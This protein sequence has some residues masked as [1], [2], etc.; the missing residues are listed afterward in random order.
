MSAF[1]TY[2][3]RKAGIAAR[4][5]PPSLIIITESP[6][7]ISAGAPVRNS[8]VA[9]KTALRNLI[10]DCGSG[11]TIRG[12]TVCH[13]SGRCFDMLRGLRTAF[14][15]EFTWVPD[16]RKASTPA[17]R[18]RPLPCHLRTWRNG[19]HDSRSIARSAGP[20]RSQRKIPCCNRWTL[21]GLLRP[22]LHPEGVVPA[23]RAGPE[24]LLAVL[25]NQGSALS[26]LCKPAFDALGPVFDRIAARAHPPPGTPTD[27]L[28]KLCQWTYA[29]RLYC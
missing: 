3:W 19:V 24:L 10:S 5:P 26:M 21:G 28:A 13:P 17:Q 20:P 12:V 27:L 6:I 23:G 14:A 7:L 4:K 9:S 1:A 18:Q 29:W 2:T 22:S 8:P 15:Q 16:A 25:Y 11:T